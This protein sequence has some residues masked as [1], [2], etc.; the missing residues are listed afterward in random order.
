MSY[1][2]DTDDFETEDPTPVVPTLSQ[3][4]L[5]A[6]TK[7]E[8]TAGT[9]P[10]QIAEL[11]ARKNELELEIDR[12]VAVVASHR[13]SA[14][15]ARSAALDEEWKRK[16]A[17]EEAQ[18]NPVDYEAIQMALDFIGGKLPWAVLQDDAVV[19]SAKEMDDSG[20][21]YN[22]TFRLLEVRCD[23]DTKHN[24][25]LRLYRHAYGDSA[26]IRFFATKQEAEAA[27]LAQAIGK[28]QAI[29]DG[30]KGKPIDKWGFD[31]K[32]ETERFR[33]NFP[34]HVEMLPP[35]CI[36]AASYM[37]FSQRSYAASTAHDT[38]KNWTES[39]KRLADSAT[40]NHEAERAYWAA[41]ESG[42]VVG[43][44]ANKTARMESAIAQAVSVANAIES[45]LAAAHVAAGVVA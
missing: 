32:G 18:S 40:P 19:S 36:I 6:V 33:R 9:L 7:W 11:T 8:S 23:R 34:D 3:A 24:P 12:L 29:V 45:G 42:A 10:T 17:I 26:P 43:P 25:K 15:A 16:R 27:A 1:N 37:A 30:G 38:V 2:D 5:E 13:R 39:V 28:I 35:E 4:V 44:D 14:E 22:R 20:P 31:L 21:R 41:L